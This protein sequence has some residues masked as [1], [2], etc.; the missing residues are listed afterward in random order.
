MRTLFGSI[1]SVLV[2][3]V[4]GCNTVDPD[5][6]WVNTSGGFGGGGDIPIGAGVG[7]TSSGDFITPPPGGPLAAD[8]TENPCVEMGSIVRVDFRPSEFPFVT[9]VQD[10]GTGPGGGWQEARA[11]L[12]FGKRRVDGTRTAWYCPVTIGMPLRNEAYGKVSVSRAAGFSVDV[13]EEVAYKMNYN[14]PPGIFCENFILGVR[15]AFPSMYPG[16]GATV[17]K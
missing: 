14:L 4:I 13:T 16:L 8:G 5:E 3:L 9:I 10:D 7:A 17:M 6:C 12:E 15:A 1:A 2:V 11:N